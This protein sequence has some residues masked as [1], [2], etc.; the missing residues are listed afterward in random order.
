MLKSSS[1]VCTSEDGTVPVAALQPPE[2][3]ISPGK[4]EDGGQAVTADTSSAPSSTEE[5]G[6]IFAVVKN[7]SIVKLRAQL[8]A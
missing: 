7:R 4:S 3:I 5:I 8:W 2:N 1:I 6:C